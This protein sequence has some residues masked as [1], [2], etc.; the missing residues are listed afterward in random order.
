M[1]F[2]KTN[3]DD[4]ILIESDI[5]EDHRGEYIEFY[6]EDDFKKMGINIKFVADDISISHK[7][8]LRG[9]HGDEETWKLIT[10]LYGRI[11]C[12]IVNCNIESKKFGKWQSFILS[13]SNRHR[14]LIPPNYGNSF[15]TLSDVSVYYYKQSCYYKPR[16]QFTY[17]WNDPQFNI[18][19]PIKDPILS[20]R[21]TNGD[22]VDMGGHNDENLLFSSQ[23]PK[24]KWI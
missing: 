21:D 3:L 4:V 20:Q 22:Y 19:W 24:G 5:F 17:K 6:N 2:N 23:G 13:S 9:I 11:Y 7:N 14:L 18:W 1:K 12:V 8:V 10:C 15:L 16:G